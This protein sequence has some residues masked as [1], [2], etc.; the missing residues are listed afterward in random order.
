MPV[1]GEEDL[2][3][4]N[5]KEAVTRFREW[6]KKWAEIE[7]KAVLCL[8]KDIEKMLHF[9]DLPE[10][11]RVTMRTSNPIERVFREVR[12]RTRTISCFTNRRS[13]NRMVYALLTYQN[14]KWDAKHLPTETTHKT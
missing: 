2:S 8:T 3:C 12:R 14:R 10:A 9:L 13:V 6:R 7:P 1:W 4:E 5:R 11:D